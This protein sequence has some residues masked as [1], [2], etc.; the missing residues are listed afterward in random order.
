MQEE[1]INKYIEVTINKLQDAV[2]E[3][4][5]ATAKAEFFTKQIEDLQKVIKDLQEKHANELEALRV[6]HEADLL[7]KQRHFEEATENF[8]RIRQE[9][10]INA[11][12]GAAQDRLEWNA[13]KDMLEKKITKLQE[14]LAKRGKVKKV[15]VTQEAAPEV[16]T[17]VVKEPDDFAN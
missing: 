17:L 4:L 2:K 3:G 7:G 14:R 12:Q 6:Q 10:L 11:T 8:Q 9:D 13:E 1:F 16:L 5:L 15:N